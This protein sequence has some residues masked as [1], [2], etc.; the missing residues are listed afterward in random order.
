M[1]QVCLSQYAV[2]KVLSMNLQRS[3]SFFHGASEVKTISIILR[4]YF[5]FS[6]V[7]I[8]GEP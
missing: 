4:C 3:L 2:L 6:N 7:V 8:V 5:P 1:I